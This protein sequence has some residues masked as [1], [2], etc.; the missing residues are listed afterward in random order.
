MKKTHWKKLDNPNYLGAYSLMDGETKDITVTISKVVTEEVK[1]ERGS[2]T[3]RVAYFKESEINGIKIKPMILNATNSKAIG[4]IYDTP[5]IE[6]WQNKQVTIYVAKVRAFGDEIECLR[7]KREKPFKK[8]PE[9][10]PTDEK[11][12]LKVI[13][14]MQ[15]GFTIDQIKTKLSI[16]TENETKLK[17]EI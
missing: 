9:L 10:L 5:Y 16:S 3:C 12:W 6:D 7:I 4:K 14:A 15:Q 1:N 2:E 17:S 8:L 13:A 11:N